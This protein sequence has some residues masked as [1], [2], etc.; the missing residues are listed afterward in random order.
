MSDSEERLR[1]LQMIEDGKITAA[2]GLRLLNA[3][4]GS[5]ILS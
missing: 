5:P 3:L 4:S 2:E 1:V